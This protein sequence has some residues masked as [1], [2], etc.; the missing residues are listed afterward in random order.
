MKRWAPILVGII[1]T[2][3][4]TIPIPAGAYGKE[5][6]YRWPISDERVRSLQPGTSTRVDVLLSLG[7]PD[8]SLEGDRYF[9][10]QWA[11]E[12]MMP[13]SRYISQHD[14]LFEFDEAGRVVRH[15]DLKTLLED[16]LG[17]DRPPAA[18]AAST[19]PIQSSVW[20][21]WID[22][23]LVLKRNGLRLEFSEMKDQDFTIPPGS[24][25]VFEY[26]TGSE[27]WTGGTW[28]RYKLHFRDA[29]GDVHK[30]SIRVKADYLIP[31]ARYLHQHT[32]EIRIY[33]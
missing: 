30:V 18:G 31:L 32:P 12:K 13:E 8:V 6:A 29:S 23:R 20:W 24:A 25:L 16:G 22:G 1:L 19:I 5:R 11:T 27:S 3:C 15:G 10:Y 9:L 4:I 28:R 17:R 33:D 21:G 7:A 26:Q 14:L 2:G